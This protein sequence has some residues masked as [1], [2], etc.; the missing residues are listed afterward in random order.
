MGWANGLPLIVH[1]NG[2]GA[3]AGAQHDLP[4]RAGRGAGQGHALTREDQHEGQR[5]GE[6]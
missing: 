3:S 4:V 6:V 2:H 1:Q 5:E